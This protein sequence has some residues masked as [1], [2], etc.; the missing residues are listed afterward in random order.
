MGR[1]LRHAAVCSCQKLI[2]SIQHLQQAGCNTLVVGTSHEKADCPM[3]V[4]KKPGMADAHVIKCGA[5][6]NRMPLIAYMHAWAQWANAGNTSHT[7]T[8][9]HLKWQTVG[10]KSKAKQTAHAPINDR[11]S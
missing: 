10:T 6:K 5:I 1:K 3:T 11:L 9:A 4:I 2:N 8:P 7:Q